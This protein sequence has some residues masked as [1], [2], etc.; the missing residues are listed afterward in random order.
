MPIYQSIPFE[1]DDA[2]SFEKRKYRKVLYVLPAVVIVMALFTLRTNLSSSLSNPANTI[3]TEEDILVKDSLSLYV[4]ASNEYTS[5]S[6][7]GEAYPFLRDAIVVE[8]MK[9]TNMTANIATSEDEIQSCAWS[10][11]SH[12]SGGVYETKNPKTASIVSSESAGKKMIALFPMPSQYTIT[13]QCSLLS[14]DSLKLS[15][16]VQAFYVR[17]ELRSLTDSD[18]TLFLDSLTVLMKTSTAEG[19]VR[20]G[21]NYK[22]LDSLVEMHLNAAGKRRN[23]GLHDG[24][25]F[26][27][28]HLSITQTAEL[29]LQSVAPSVTIPY[30]DY[31]IDSQRIIEIQGSGIDV[32][33]YS[34]LFTAKWFGATDKDNR[35]GDGRF[36]LQTVT[37]N[38]SNDETSPYG[39]LR[40]PWN[41]NPSSYV[42]RYQTMCGKYADTRHESSAVEATDFQWPSCESH[43]RLVFAKEMNNWY[44]WSW[45]SSYLPHGPVH[46]W[47]GGMGGDCETRFDR[48][49]SVGFSD[50]NI[51][52]AKLLSFENIKIMWRY[53]LMEVPKFCSNDNL[54]GCVFYCNREHPKFLHL[55]NEKVMKSLTNFN[56][57]SEQVLEAANIMF[58]DKAQ[59]WAGD[60][61]E[62]G[63]PVEASFWSIH[64]TLERLYQYKQII[65]PF[66]NITWNSNAATYCAWH[67]IGDC[68]GHHAEDLTFWKTIV[69]EDNGTYVEKYRSNTEVRYAANPK[70]YGLPYIYDNFRWEHCDSSKIYFPEYPIPGSDYSLD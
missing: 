59:Y 12:S 20:F 66:D 51:T 52:Q 6:R 37:S 65:Q 34:E 47:I 27:T 56:L 1:T 57:T 48:L 18:R 33:K 23:D 62:S 14:G 19:R 58:C 3:L 36:R 41:V 16:T 55:V 13:V 22:G 46:V 2:H 70:H 35:I 69:K 5:L 54:D 61:L 38:T 17:R 7:P 68:K 45:H 50:E 60:H 39:F 15:Q 4:N 42:T 28:Q 53:E 63:S 44:H 67:S 11:R 26:F 21:K 24:M 10:I 30:W 29:S 43:W 9:A 40:A 32:F 25:G 49:A 8:P 64:P 31:T